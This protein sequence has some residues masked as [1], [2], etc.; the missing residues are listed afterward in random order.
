MNVKKE[1]PTGSRTSLSGRGSAEQVLGQVVE[2]DRE[3]RVVLEPAEQSEK[4]G[5]GPERGRIPRPALESVDRLSA[6]TQAM[7]VDAASR[8]T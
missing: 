3:E 5:E 7:V 1:I 6:P 8:K 2:V 4:A